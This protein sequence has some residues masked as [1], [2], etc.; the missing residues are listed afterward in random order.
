MD[1]CIFVHYGQSNRLPMT[2]FYYV[3]ELARYFSKV[4]VVTNSRDFQL[5][6]LPQHVRLEMVKNE[7][8][9]FGMFY[10]VVQNLD[11]EQ[12]ACLALA[13]DSNLLLGDLGENLRKGKELDTDFWGLIDSFEKPWFSTHAD[14][15]HLQSHFLVW[16]KKG[17]SI[18]R[19]FLQEIK[20]E[21]MFSESDP[22]ELRRKVI[23]A[24]EIGLSQYFISRNSRPKAIFESE[25]ITSQLGKKRSLN[26]TMKHPAYLLE[27]GYPLLKKKYIQ[28][29]GWL[30]RLL[31]PGKKW[32]TLVSKYQLDATRCQ[33][34]ISVL[35]KA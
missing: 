12:L 13:N 32:E 35:K 14:N 16:N 3:S 33:Q 6:D 18:L 30:D 22:K 15:F 2:D 21:E 25:K 31:R 27:M 26:L 34:W 23:N 7:G 4:I 5:T 10:K 19:D 1:C 28:K 8:Y 9:D 11:W 24:W 29:N 17:I 20:V